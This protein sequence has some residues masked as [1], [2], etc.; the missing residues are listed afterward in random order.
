[1]FKNYIWGIIWLILLFVGAFLVQPQNILNSIG[2]VLLSISGYF[3]FM[4]MEDD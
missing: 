2:A 3:H 1:M 4:S